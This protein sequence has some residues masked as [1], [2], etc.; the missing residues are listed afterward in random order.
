VV[1]V[2]ALMING[3]FFRI[4]PVAHKNQLCHEANFQWSC[5]IHGTHGDYSHR[6]RRHLL[7]NQLLS[8]SGWS[9]IFSG[10]YCQRINF[11]NSNT[12]EFHW[13]DWRT[14]CGRCESR[15]RPWTKYMFDIYLDIYQWERLTWHDG[16]N[17][18]SQ[19]LYKDLKK[20]ITHLQD[21]TCDVLAQLI[22]TELHVAFAHN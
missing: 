4:V 8:I 5:H 3:R 20:K 14:D 10:G 19:G 1:V 21:L 9:S 7:V 17:T 12:H 22:W 11:Q 18:Q 15:I 16:I 6:S 2:Q 13:V